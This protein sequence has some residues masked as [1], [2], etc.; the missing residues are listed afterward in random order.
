VREECGQNSFGRGP[1]I[2][3]YDSLYLVN[4][5]SVPT[6]RS[7]NSVEDLGDAGGDLPVLSNVWQLKIKGK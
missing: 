1:I 2:S 6:K 3:P 7:W 4:I 5:S